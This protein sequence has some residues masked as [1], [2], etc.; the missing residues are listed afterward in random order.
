MVW[1]P[2]RRG[3]AWEEEDCGEG[4]DRGC[5]L[6]GDRWRDVVIR[7][8]S[9]RELLQVG[10]GRRWR[11]AMRCALLRELRWGLWM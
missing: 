8:V 4:V 2:R 11:G 7:S 5:G 3:G 10:L 9:E 1:V 6:L